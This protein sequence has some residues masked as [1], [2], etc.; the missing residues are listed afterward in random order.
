MPL[1]LV[2]L[3]KEEEE[4]EEEEE[5]DAYRLD[6]RL[7]WISEGRWTSIRAAITTQDS[8]TTELVDYISLEARGRASFLMWSFRSPV[9]ECRF[10]GVCLFKH[11]PID[12]PAD[13]DA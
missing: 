8:D 2:D 11:L 9:F 5:E 3:P 7:G 10:R 13:D 6:R 12:V 4:E 1:F